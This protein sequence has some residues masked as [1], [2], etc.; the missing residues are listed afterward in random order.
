MGQAVALLQSTSQRHESMQSISG[1]DAMPE[2]SI[3]QACLPQRIALHE[4]GPEQSMSQ[5]SPSVQSTSPHAPAWLHRMVHSKPAGHRTAAHGRLPV[6][7]IR[8][9][10]LPMLHELHSPGHSRSTQ[11]PRSQVRSLPQSPL[12]LHA[13][14]SD[15]R[16][17]EQPASASAA[18]A[19]V[20]RAVM[21]LRRW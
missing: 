14:L 21:G 12:L 6:H 17:T 15:C 16:W 9:V 18:S 10:R 8:Q 2:Q 7:S 4:A 20:G 13:K 1:H 5:L 19:I 11:N 3:E